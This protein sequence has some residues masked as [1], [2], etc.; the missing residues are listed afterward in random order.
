MKLSAN[1][2]KINFL[3]FFG[4]I[5]INHAK[6]IFYLLGT[7]Y[8][9]YIYSYYLN[10][11]DW[12]GDYGLYILQ[13]K[14]LQSGTLDTLFE[15]VNLSLS[16]SKNSLPYSPD[17]Y[18]FGLPVIF[19]ITNI[20]HKWN[21]VFLK[22]LNPIVLVAI[23]FL[24][25]KITNLKSPQD[26]LLSFLSIVVTNNLL[27][28]SNL[29]PSLVSS[30]FIILSYLFF[31]KNQKNISILFFLIACTVRTNSVFFVIYF[32]LNQKFKNNILY[33]LKL[34][35]IFIMTYLTPTLFFKINI[36]GKYEFSPIYE[37]NRNLL[38]LE[39]F[40]SECVDFLTKLSELIFFVRFSEAT[41]IGLFLIFCVVLMST[42]HRE[43][44]VVLFFLF[45][46]F[47]INYF[48]YLIDFKRVITPI[49]FVSI[50]FLSKIKLNNV[51]IFILSV[52]IIYNIFTSLNTVQN[53]DKSQNVMSEGFY[54]VVN[55]LNKD[56]GNEL[57]GFS[58]PR[59]LMLYSDVI[60]YK[61]TSENFQDVQKEGLVL[62]NKNFL[63][64]PPFSS[65][66]IFEN[67][68]FKIIKYE[69]FSN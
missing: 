37:Q 22:L 2:L 60:S 25:I 3:N 52:F 66:T 36:F 31:D 17:Y 6:K 28:F 8:V 44:L 19:T 35:L 55:V 64:C 46:S 38:N 16:L 53:I 68:D 48:V 33:F 43:F 30:F 57:I 9:S 18:P 11:L 69:N 14:S 62:C 58:K 24:F 26:Y 49:I 42:K 56:Y 47:F 65:E 67:Y 34:F 29:Q 10:Y 54:E 50:Y 5:R 12:S 27:F 51:S 39:K 21:I 63:N 32:L 7:A 45:C 61:L 40:Y 1:N 59:V 15:K 23:F 41:Y 13:A 20:F 4:Y